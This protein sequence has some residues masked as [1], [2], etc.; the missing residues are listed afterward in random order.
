MRTADPRKRLQQNV[1]YYAEHGLT[2]CKR[3]VRYPSSSRIA[4]ITADIA[5]CSRLS[6]IVRR[7]LRSKVHPN[8]KV[9]SLAEL[10]NIIAPIAKELGIER[11]YVFGSYARGEATPESDVNNLIDSGNI[12]S[13]FG[14]GRLYSKLNRALEKDLDIIP[15]DASA[16][17]IN[18]IRPDLVLVYAE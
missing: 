11:V 4:R 12:D 6:I 7:E 3:K 2:H 16:D 18:R 17:F 10:A 5:F 14:I 9:Y 13:Y 15:S 8:G 1:E